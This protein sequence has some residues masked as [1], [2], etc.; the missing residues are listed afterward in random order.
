MQK[1]GITIKNLTLTYERRPAVH[2]VSGYFP[3]GSMTAIIGPNGAGKSTFLKSLAGLHPIDE[4]FIERCPAHALKDTAYLPQS[5][6]WD[7]N[8]PISVYDLAAQALARERG[9][10]RSWNQIQKDR[11]QCALE[12]VN[13]WDQRD[14]TIDRLSLGQFQRALFAR[15]IIQNAQLILLDE[16]LT[17][18][19]EISI[20]DFFC[21]IHDWNKKGKTIIV[22]LHDR[23]LI[24][25]HFETT[26]L[27]SKEVRAWG[28]SSTILSMIQEPS[29]LNLSVPSSLTNEECLR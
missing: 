2:H 1:P 7:R 15:V 4:G 8:F 16:P 29:T 12:Q 22:V 6:N 26:I 28:S 11:I 17:G 18:L 3:L 20:H 5:S 10:W 9:F 21:L 27:L 25:Q 14:L 23:N 24:L 13:L 19:D